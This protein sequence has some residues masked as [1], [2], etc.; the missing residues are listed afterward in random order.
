M[1]SRSNQ[2]GKENYLSPTYQDFNAVSFGPNNNYF[3]SGNDSS[4]PARMPLTTKSLGIEAVLFPSSTVAATM[5]KFDVVMHQVNYR[6]IPIP[7]GGARKSKQFG[8]SS[9]HMSS[10]INYPDQRVERAPG[11]LRSNQSKKQEEK[12]SRSKQDTRKIK[13]KL[14]A[15]LKKPVI[16]KPSS[17]LI[18]LSERLEEFS[19]LFSNEFQADRRK[20][21]QDQRS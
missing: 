6:P 2:G 17:T 10:F 21:A 4:S 5:P 11:P 15:T 20:F 13:K 18:P 8:V 1:S 16:H 7:S 14:F 19:W 3:S 12:R 9:T